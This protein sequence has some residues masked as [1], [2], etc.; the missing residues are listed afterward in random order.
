MRT[1]IEDRFLSVHVDPLLCCTLVGRLTQRAHD[2]GKASREI[3][4]KGENE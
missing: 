4:I 1:V 2:V 3:M